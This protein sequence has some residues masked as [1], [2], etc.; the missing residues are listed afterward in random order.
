MNRRVLVRIGTL[1]VAATA[2]SL[3]L[4]QPMQQMPMGPNM[5]GMGCP[6]M[7]MMRQDGM[8]GMMNQGMMDPG[9]MGPQVEGR[10][11]YLKAELGITDAQAAAWKSYEDAIRSRTSAM[12]GMRQEMMKAMQTGTLA[13]RLKA[14]INMMEG[15]LASMK[16]QSAGLEGLYKVLTEEQKKKADQLLGS[17]MM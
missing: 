13:D 7:G 10:L 5:M 16:A 12:Q 17:G 8:Q 2:T 6:M 4:A 14:R 15:M 3:A 9:S 1:I 11:A